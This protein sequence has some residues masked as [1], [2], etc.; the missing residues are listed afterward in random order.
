MNVRYFFIPIVH[1]KGTRGKLSHVVLITAKMDKV[2]DSSRDP[3]L[4]RSLWT[5]QEEGF[6]MNTGELLG[7][8]W[9]RSLGPD[10]QG[11]YVLGGKL[12]LAYFFYHFQ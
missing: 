10:P 5:Q 6:T 2:V 1:F 7:R 12:S 11:V 3:N 9:K 8:R 4:S